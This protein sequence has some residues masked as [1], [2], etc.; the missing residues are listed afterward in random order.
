M[1]EV[2]DRLGA[3]GHQ[4]ADVVAGVDRGHELQAVG[5]LDPAAHLG[6]DPA[7]R[8]EHAH[9]DLAVVTASTYRPGG[10]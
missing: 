7:S 1:G 2:D 8:A 3:R 4:R 10:A 9:L 6:A 5:R